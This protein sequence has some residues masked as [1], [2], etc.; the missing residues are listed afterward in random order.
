MTAF[1]EVLVDSYMRWLRDNT[2]FRPSS[3]GWVEVQTPFLDRNNDF[4]SIHVRH[5]T[6][7]QVELTDDSYTLSDLELSGVDVDAAPKRREIFG[8]I[9]RSHGLQRVGDELRV[10][11]TPDSFPWRK[12]NFVQAI[13]EI[14]DLFYL[15]RTTVANLFLEDVI[16]WFD[17]EEIP[18][19]HDLKIVGKSGL[20]HHFDLA[21][22]KLGKR[23][24]RLIRAIN[25]PDKN[26]AIRMTHSAVDI[27]EV[28][29]DATT[30]A[31]VNDHKKVSGEFLEALKQYEVTTVLWKQRE[32]SLSLLRPA[33]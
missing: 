6:D 17:G 22:P 26:A 29:P 21:V 30:I 16:N 7:G 28:R 14:N 24:E 18:Y 20:D 31:I 9:L 33:A 2:K 1:E 12:H 13:L 25:H 8:N 32:Q 10:T 19:T 11:C 3:S 27:R 4:I 23:P 5:N 15:T